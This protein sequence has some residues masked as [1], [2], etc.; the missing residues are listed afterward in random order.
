[1]AIKTKTNRG[2]VKRFKKT[3]GGYKRKKAYLRH[4]MRKR[5]QDVKRVLRKKTMVSEADEPRVALMLGN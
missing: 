1:M 2:A 3:S 4:N 5:K